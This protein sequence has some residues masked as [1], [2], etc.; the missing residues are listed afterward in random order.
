MKK[1][2]L[3]LKSLA[4]L[5][6]LAITLTLTI[7]GDEDRPIAPVV[8]IINPAP[9]TLSTGFNFQQDSKL[10]RTLTTSDA[11]VVVTN[12]KLAIHE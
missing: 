7:Y 12:I 2:L 9:T 5:N 6:T 4:L 3:S 8:T 11:K 10:T 1:I